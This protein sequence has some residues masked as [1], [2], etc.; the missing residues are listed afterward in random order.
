MKHRHLFLIPAAL[1]AATVAGSA[2]TTEVTPEHAPEQVRIER[3]FRFL[4][5]GGSY[6][7]VHIEEVTPESMGGLGLQEEYGA[8]VKEVVKNTPAETAG[9]QSKDVIVGWN[10]QR[11]E[12]TKQLRRL[13]AETPAGRTVKIEYIRNGARAE[14]TTKIAE[15]PEATM[16]FM[17]NDTL[18]L[19]MERNMLSMEGDMLNMERD[20]LN[21]ERNMILGDTMQIFAFG[22]CNS[23]P[24][25]GVH[26]APVESQI[27]E[28]LGGKQ[29]AGAL[30]SSV[31]EKSAAE[32]AGVKAGDVIIAIDKEKVN[33]PGDLIRILAEKAEGEVALTIIRDKREMTITATL[34]KQNAGAPRFKIF[35]WNGAAPLMPAVPN[36]PEMLPVPDSDS[37]SPDISLRPRR[38]MRGMPEVKKVIE[39]AEKQI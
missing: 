6:L 27:A 39:M 11:V 29:E 5:D 38:Q 34:A 9:L 20:M 31:I 18:M 37:D 24:R 15:R 14:A 19:N 10:G 32:T 26:L 17:G 2:Q 25:L 16:P 4:F 13:I 23:R 33:N 3:N 1:L 36:L 8:V 21:M 35:E 22:G 7:G 12:S 30:V 28:E